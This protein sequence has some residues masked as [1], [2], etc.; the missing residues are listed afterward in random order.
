[1][2]LYHFLPYPS[3]PLL[4]RYI[5]TRL[6]KFLEPLLVVTITV[7][8]SYLIMFLSSECRPLGT[9]E[10]YQDSYGGPSKVGC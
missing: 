3:L 2:D 10:E 4:P 7:T 1:M 9:Q 5:R 8:A 6:M